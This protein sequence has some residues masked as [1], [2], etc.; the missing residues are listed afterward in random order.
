ML[1]VGAGLSARAFP[2]TPSFRGE[3][4]KQR[5]STLGGLH[6]S[7]RLRVSAWARPCLA[8]D[9]GGAG[10]GT[11]HEQEANTGYTCLQRPL[12]LS[13]LTLTELLHGSAARGCPI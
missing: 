10:Q 5:I 13:V 6:D 7:A 1:L 11:V 12:Q 2:R 3:A 9:A 8:P 4:F